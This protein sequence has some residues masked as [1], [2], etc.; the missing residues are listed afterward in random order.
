M[1]FKAVVK[2][3]R[4]VTQFVKAEKKKH[5]R[6]LN[7]AIKVEGYRLRTLLIKEMK[8]GAPGGVAFAPL[9]VISRSFRG[10]QMSGSRY[11]YTQYR[12]PLR[13]S[14]E[15][16][17]YDVQDKDPIRMAIGWTGSKVSKKWKRIME[18]QQEGFSAPISEGM[19][20][21]WRAKG[22][23]LSKRSKN[24]NYHFLKRST[25][26]GRTP[27]RPIIEPFWRA[28][29]DEAA[30]NIRRNFLRKLQGKRI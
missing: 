15:A 3:T 12:K 17:R 26:R 9:R 4:K 16:I 30:K 10:N 24:R 2:G 20:Q 11:R 27:A 13:R 18:K 22:A 6:S 19:G 23:K 5:R 14:V 29:K 8:A 28:H 25:K 21:F 7:T 1:E